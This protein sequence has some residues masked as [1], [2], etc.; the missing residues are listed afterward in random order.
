MR[1]FQILTLRLRGPVAKKEHYNLSCSV[2]FFVICYAY[3]FPFSSFCP[4]KRF[5]CQMLVLRGW[6]CVPRSITNGNLTGLVDQ[7]ARFF[8]S[9]SS[10][11]TPNSSTTLCA[12]CLSLSLSLSYSYSKKVFVSSDR[13]PS[14]LSAPHR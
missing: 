5:N 6:R 11:H 7:Y 3:S 4:W 1:C 2:L 8:C 10:R 12:H 14:M 13:S 9:T